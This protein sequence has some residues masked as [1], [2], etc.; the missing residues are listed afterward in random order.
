[1][2]ESV[3]K[4]LEDKGNASVITG[5]NVFA[6]IDD[7]HLLMSNVKRLLKKK[8]FLFLRPHIL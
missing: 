7:L 1:M 4:I 6:H 8:E 5:H 2:T 3:D